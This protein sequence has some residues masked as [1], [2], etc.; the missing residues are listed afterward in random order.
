MLP[1]RDGRAHLPGLGAL[2][3]AAFPGRSVAVS[4]DDAGQATTPG[5]DSVWLPIRRAQWRNLS[6]ALEDT[7][8]FRDCQGWPPV[9][10]LDASQVSAWRN[11]IITAVRE[12]DLV[13]PAYSAP[14]RAG[15][16]AVVPLAAAPAAYNRS[17]TGRH[18][19]GGIGVAW[20]DDLA[21]LLLHEF[22]HVKLNALL[23]LYQLLDPA[24]PISVR[25][26]W[27][28]D[29]RPAEGVLHGVYAHLAVT[30]LW[31]ARSG[32]GASVAERYV[33]F[34]SFRLHRDDFASVIDTLAGMGVLTA[35]GEAFVAGMYRTAEQWMR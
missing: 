14:L 29:P 3:M 30:A 19:F 18:V 17:G 15:L 4:V 21:V 13:L 25:V 8:P 35:A 9:P 12:L 1:V 2:L 22:Q 31:R 6:V 32:S 27:R 11:A 26:P 34:K 24:R 16:R 5:L 10:R 20:P 23:D 33:A 7:D 28:P